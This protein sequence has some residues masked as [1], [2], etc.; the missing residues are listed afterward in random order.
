[1]IQNTKQVFSAKL[2]STM[3]EEVVYNLELFVYP[4]GVSE[5][6]CPMYVNEFA[7]DAPW[8]VSE[9]AFFCLFPNCRLK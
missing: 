6:I 7:A 5:Y 3:A 4:E 9:N 1:M 2:S 8:N